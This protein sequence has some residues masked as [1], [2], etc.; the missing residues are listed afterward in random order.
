MAEQL[1][2]FQTQHSNFRETPGTN[3]QMGVRKKKVLLTLAVVFVAAV[4][5]VMVW[6]RERDP[7][8]QGKKLSEWLAIAYG[9][10]DP[11]QQVQIVLPD[12]ETSRSLHKISG[13]EGL[14]AN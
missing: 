1:I 8:Y 4:V 3:L 5:T 11:S 2:K 9:S 14:A 6:P 7:E 13:A 10:P 12:P